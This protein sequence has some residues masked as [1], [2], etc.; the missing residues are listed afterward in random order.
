MDG[1]IK[2]PIEGK[3][4]GMSVCLFCFPL[5]YINSFFF[6]PLKRYANNVEV[7]YDQSARFGARFL[8]AACSMCMCMWTMAGAEWKY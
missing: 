1:I 8:Y 6:S 4:N 3:L 5:A 7:D 2:S